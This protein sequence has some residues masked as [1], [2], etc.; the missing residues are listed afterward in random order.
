M[1]G[2]KFGKSFE[3]V[4]TFAR[5]VSKSPLLPAGT[6]FWRAGMRSSFT[7]D[8]G[9]EA[10]LW[11][12]LRVFALRCGGDGKSTTMKKVVDANGAAT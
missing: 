11:W 9:D 10:A 1:R 2:K 6:Q 7:T 8:L 4:L 12:V 3:K 5:H